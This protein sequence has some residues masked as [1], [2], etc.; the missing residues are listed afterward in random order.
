MGSKPGFEFPDG[1][2]FAFT[3][4]DDTD[5]ATVANVRPIYDLL[6][7]LG[8]RTTKTV[9]P[10]GCP[11]GSPNYSTSETLEDP[12]YL[13]FVR[14]LATRGFEITWHSATME[15]STRER[16]LEG[17]H[18]FHDLIGH[19]PRIHANHSFN[20]ENLYWGAGRFD[21]PM[22]RIIFGPLSGLPPDHFQGHI[23]GSRYWWGD[24][25]EEHI[26]YGR[27]LT[28]EEINLLM[29]NPSMPYRDAR[30]PLIK[31][32]FS[33]TDA[34]DVIA[35][36]HM[37]RRNNLD[38]LEDEGGVCIVATHFG[39]RFVNEGVLNQETRAVLEDVARRDGWF[40][41]VGVLLD[42]LRQRR[43]S[44]QLPPR[45]WRRMQRRWAVD[46]VHRKMN[47]KRRRRG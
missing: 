4:I 9:W 2:R 7:S 12:V 46:L 43:G 15:S 40:P 22:L 20:R 28:F 36:N 25:C 31:W 1:K 34:E 27:N 33:A 47:E 21:N 14:E 44:G 41:P 11:E 13:A 30:R 26:E 42:W 8:M 18:R 16:T 45:E 17:L 37:L 32:W 6:Y 39:K 5:V 24:L 35:F 10:L 38:R 23:A 29:V 3:V 19:Y